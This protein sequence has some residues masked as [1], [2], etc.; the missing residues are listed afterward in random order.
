LDYPISTSLAAAFRRSHERL[1]Q[2]I[3]AAGAEEAFS[4][5]LKSHRM[6][7]QSDVAGLGALSYGAFQHPVFSAHQMGGCA[8]GP[9]PN[10]SVVDE[11]LKIHGLRNA[12]VVDGSVLPTSL[13]VNPSETIYGMA[14]R[15]SEW[16]TE[17]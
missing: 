5:H 7:T 10:T 1:A 17:G 9:D 16:I 6:A 2:V 3:L 15:A 13:G 12:Y 11:R 4:M 14:H 8:M